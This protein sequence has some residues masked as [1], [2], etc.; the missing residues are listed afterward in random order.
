MNLP[1]KSFSPGEVK[2]CIFSFPLN[3]APDYDL[4]TAEVVRQLPKRAIILLT[5]SYTNIVTNIY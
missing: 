5:Y 1:P 3:K 4:I 2:C